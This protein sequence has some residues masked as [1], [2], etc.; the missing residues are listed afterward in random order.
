MAISNY[1]STR[2]HIQRVEQ[3]RERER[4]QIERF[5]QG[6][7]K[8]IRHIFESKGLDGEL[9]DELVEAIT[10]DRRT[11][12]ETMLCEELGLQVDTPHPLYAAG[13]TFLAFVLVGFIPL[14]PF[15]FPDLDPNRAFL[16]SGIATGVGFLAVGIVKGLVLKRSLLRSGLET[17][18]TGGI[19]A[20]LAYFVGRWIRQAYGGGT[21]IG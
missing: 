6:E 12:V 16:I 21:G 20:V 8:E 7:R 4:R 19:T 9:L 3:A 17:L 1:L 14:A 18:L 2:S 10:E 13:A 5:P 11:W 15:L